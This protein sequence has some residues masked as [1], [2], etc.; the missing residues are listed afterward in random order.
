[1]KTTSCQPCRMEQDVFYPKLQWMDP[2]V[3]R[4]QSGAAIVEFRYSR[5]E[6]ETRATSLVSTTCIYYH[7]MKHGTM[8]DFL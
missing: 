3:F 1:M 4:C 6:R 2:K 7:N 8:D 5:T